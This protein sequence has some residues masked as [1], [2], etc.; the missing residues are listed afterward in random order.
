MREEIVV[1]ASG[2]FD[3]IHRGHI[4]YLQKARELGTKLVVILNNNMQCELKKKKPFYSMDDKIA[5]LSALS[6]V[7]QVVTA[8]DSDESV[9]ETLAMVNPDIFAKGGDRHAGEIPEA[10]ICGEMDIE[11]VDG[12]GR[13]I[14]SSS[15]II[16]EA[17]K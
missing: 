14:Q 1:A 2:F 12:L 15:S 11:I 3:P 7:D 4:E 10:K 17:R 13:K 16:A 5:I 9:C 6:C 8:I